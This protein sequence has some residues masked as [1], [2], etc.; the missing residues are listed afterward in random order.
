M[1]VNNFI[2]FKIRIKGALISNYKY[3]MGYYLINVRDKD[4][5]HWTCRLRNS[6]TNL[7]YHPSS[8]AQESSLPILFVFINLNINSSA[9]DLLSKNGQN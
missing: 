1:G 5:T 8:Y 3:R 7:S 9:Q 2:S 6:E 4:K